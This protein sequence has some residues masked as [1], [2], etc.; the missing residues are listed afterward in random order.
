[1]LIMNNRVAWVGER[2]RA[3]LALNVVLAG[4]LA[5]FA[6]TGAREVMRLAGW[7]D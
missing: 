4:A 5:F 2:F 7:V 6:F 3:S 1:V